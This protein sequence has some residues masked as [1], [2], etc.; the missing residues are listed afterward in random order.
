MGRPAEAT[1]SGSLAGSHRQEL[2]RVP[3]LTLDG[4][5][6]S[7]FPEPEEDQQPVR[8][9]EDAAQTTADGARETR[10]R[11]R[12]PS[13]T[14]P[15][16]PQ[17]ALPHSDAA[18]DGATA[19]QPTDDQPHSQEGLPRPGGGLFGFPVSSARRRTALPPGRNGTQPWL[20]RARVNTSPVE[21]TLFDSLPIDP[22]IGDIQPPAPE[23]TPPLAVPLLPA[24]SEALD[25]PDL[26]AACPDHPST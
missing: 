2:L 24:D 18:S 26:S 17:P 14:P 1:Y 19:H 16:D 10:Y 3:G 25:P 5:M 20:H 15:G 22:A 11:A 21:R 4:P 23:E 9:P 13:A 7:L 6:R 12:S 8:L